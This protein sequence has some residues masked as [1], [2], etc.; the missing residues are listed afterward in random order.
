VLPG[1][2]ERA[3]LE[4]GRQN[5]VVFPQSDRPRHE[6]QARRRVGNEDEIVRIGSDVRAQRHARFAEQLL[7]T[8]SEEEHRLALQLVLPL[9][10][11]L[12]D[13]ARTPNEPWFRNVTFGSRRN[14]SRK[15]V[16]SDTVR[17]VV[18]HV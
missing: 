12:E 10:V 16:P 4:V 14:S 1:Q 2:V 11:A 15:P 3:V 9:L 18:G 17:T 7:E 5:F 13:G 6:I 8:A